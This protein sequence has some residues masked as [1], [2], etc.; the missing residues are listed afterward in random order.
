[1]A[2]LSV[3]SISESLDISST[4][5]LNTLILGG[6]ILVL[7]TIT[8]YY[9]Y[10]T[11]RNS[12]ITICKVPGALPF[13]GN[14]FGG[15]GDIYTTL[16]KWADEQYASG[17]KSGAYECSLLGDRHVIL[18]NEKTV[19]FIERQRPF[20]V[21][22]MGSV[23]RA[24][25]SC[26]VD[27][28]F[29]AEG[30]FWKK[31]RR[32]VA[33]HLNH[34][35][36]NDY[37][38][39]VQ[40]VTKRLMHKWEENMRV[41]KNIENGCGATINISPDLVATSMDI[42]SLVAF[43]KDV[44]T[45]QKGDRGMGEDIKN[46]LEK[47]MFRALFPFPYWDIPIVGQYLD[48]CGWT[49]SRMKRAF[50]DVIEEHESSTSSNIADHTSPSGKVSELDNG[51]VDEGGNVI[52]R[53]RYKSFLGKIITQSK[54]EN[55]SFL[56]TDRLIGNLITMFI[57]GTETSAVT[58]NVCLYQIAIDNTGLQEELAAESCA[59]PDLKEDIDME[60]LNEKLPRLRSLMYEVLRIK[61][62]SP[63]L[64]VENKVSV[65][66]DGKVQPPN[67]K[68]FMLLQ[69]ISTLESSEVGKR[70]PRGPRNSPPS[71]FC[72]RR[73]LLSNPEGSNEPVSAIKPTFKTGFRPFGSGMRVCPGKDFAEVEMLMV[74]SSILRTFEI[75][76]LQDDHPPLKHVIRFT[77]APDVD[78]HLVLK[79]RK[80]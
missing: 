54:R 13:I 4:V 25:K 30:E 50:R 26:G 12:S 49:A 35:N 66:I 51:M 77:Q 80:N 67:T 7:V 29:A 28:L 20:K 34:K 43:A 36:V 32:I 17:N 76:G 40:I 45:L 44:D 59:L 19:S 52:E 31:D 37:M 23:D 78:I 6:V 65:E 57:A 56:T 2:P 63:F 53:H 11:N 8:A 33:P 47:I 9:K 61:G 62:P 38:R 79:P 14:P 68:M 74:L 39:F 41:A 15:V 16:E 60:V 1:M 10:A 22:R 58:M 46:L 21:E 71:D 42:I 64:E 48:G 72:P 55:T 73:W 70:T 75:V 69:Y 24:L 5:L 27:G 3:K 18:C